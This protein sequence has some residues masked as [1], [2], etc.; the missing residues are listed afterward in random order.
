MFHFNDHTR[1]LPSQAQTLH[2]LCSMS[3]YLALSHPD[4]ISGGSRGE[5][6]GAPDPPPL[7]WDLTLVWDWNSYIGRIVYHFLIGWFF[8]MKQELHFATKL[9]SSDIQKCNCFS[10]PSYDLFTSARKAVF[11]APLATGVQK[12][13]K[14]WS[15]LPSQLVDNYGTRGG[16]SKG[17]SFTSRI[18]VHGEEPRNYNVQPRL[19]GGGV[20]QK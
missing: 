8:L 17:A 14:T 5:G 10:V 2:P 1:G 20:G 15:S 16:C 4:W 13:R 12:L 3:S 7:L 6:S 9:N 18:Q 11:P 19:V